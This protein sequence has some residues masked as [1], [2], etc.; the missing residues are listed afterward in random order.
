MCYFHFSP[1]LNSPIKLFF[2]LFKGTRLQKKKNS[3]ISFLRKSELDGPSYF[4]NAPY[5]LEL[6]PLVSVD[7]TPTCHLYLVVEADSEQGAPQAPP[8]GPGKDVHVGQTKN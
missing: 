8:S 5:A 1:V 4:S 2:A 3:F 6:S 7:M